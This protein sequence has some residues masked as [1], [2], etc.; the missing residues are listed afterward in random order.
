M[1]LKKLKNFQKQLQKVGLSGSEPTTTEF[2]S[3]YIYMNSQKG[4]YKKIMLT[5]QKAV[6]NSYSQDKREMKVESINNYL[7]LQSQGE[8]LMSTS[9]SFSFLLVHGRYLHPYSK[10]NVNKQI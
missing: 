2:R 7:H 3:E 6:T 5:K 9:L 10:E 1:Q 8:N 4:E